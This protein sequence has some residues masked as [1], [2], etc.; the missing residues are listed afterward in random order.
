MNHRRQ[1]FHT[2]CLDYANS[3]PLTHTVAAFRPFAA[4]TTITPP[5]CFTTAEQAYPGGPD[6]RSAIGVGGGA[7]GSTTLCGSRMPSTG[8]QSSLILSG[9]A[10]LLIAM[11]TTRSSPGRRDHLAR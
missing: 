1:T 8:W 6:S 9:E 2:V 7:F 3:R 11:A 4:Q 5:L 10:E